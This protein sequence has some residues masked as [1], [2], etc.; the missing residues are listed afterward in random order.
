M[1]PD[2]FKVIKCTIARLMKELS[3]ESVIRGKK[4]HTK[5]PDKALQHPLHN[6]N[7]QSRVPAQ[8]M[9]WILA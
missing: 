7:R 3:L 2:E 6:V 9:L 8:D 4:A 5:M 1:R